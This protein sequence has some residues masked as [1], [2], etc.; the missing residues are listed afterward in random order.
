MTLMTSGKMK[1]RV[2]VKLA[3]GFGAVIGLVTVI[4]A[5]ALVRLS[6]LDEVIHEITN[7]GLPRFE[8]MHAIVD[9][10][11]NLT[12][13]SHGV[14]L[15]ADS[16]AQAREMARFN[17]TRGRLGEL[18]GKFDEILT[19]SG[20]D[21]E[22]FKDR[23]HAA[24]SDYL[25]SMIKFTRI[26]ED[27]SLKA[28][29]E[30]LASTLELKRAA[31]VEV[32][33][34][35][36]TQETAHLNALSARARELYYDGIR[37]LTILVSLAALIA[38]FFVW[39][40]AR[41]IGGHLRYAVRIANAIAAGKLDNEII[42][43]SRDEAGEMLAALNVMQ[44]NLFESIRDLELRNREAALVTEVSN[45]L[46]TATNL[47]EAME[48]LSRT[49]GQVLAPHVGAIYLTAN[50]LNRLDCITQWG[51]ANFAPAI[52]PDEC[53]A[54]RRS[55]SYWASDPDRDMYCAHVHAST[56]RRPYMCVPMMAQGTSLG[57]LH[58]AFAL[59]A[60]RTEVQSG[61]RL[62]VQRL[63]DQVAL[64]L[65][66]LKLRVALRDQS[67]RDPLTGLFNRRYLEESLEREL[68]LA[69]R[70][71]HSVA[72][73]MLDVDHFKKFNDSYGHDGGDAVLRAL[74]RMLTEMIRASDIAC[75][76][77][78]EEFTAILIGTRL[79]DAVKWAERLMANVR[80]LEL[81]SGSQPLGR[82]TISMGLALCPDHGADLVTLLQ[83]ADFALYEAKH[84]GRDRLIVYQPPLDASP[85]ATSSATGTGAAT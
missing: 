34:Q 11:D 29:R 3:L 14:L 54:L 59:P 45:L 76:F 75:R 5:V 53:W 16:A 83:A 28:E 81:K 55:R 21:H 72:V 78:G 17:R 57:M 79:A 40:L 61:E 26:V 74:A 84:A 77:G 7:R 30:R 36:R 48:I 35:Y 32:L 70:Q 31:L 27:R 25:V 2:G 65:A 50:S 44:T 20:K 64:A 39:W 85:A 13:D 71:G 63:A 33:Q 24:T 19:V 69:R 23:L 52:S 49:I 12:R 73:F 41:S 62:S 10:A 68:A 60:G 58:V 51:D 67:I 47:K 42:S 56:L 43:G 80:N 15:A 22:S 1:L 6:T 38:I 8:L 82:I 66:N 18:L 4:V 46:Q 9:Q 37:T